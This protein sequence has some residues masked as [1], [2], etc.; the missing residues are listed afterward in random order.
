MEDSLAKTKKKG[1]MPLLVLTILLTLMTV[2]TLIP[3]TAASKVCLIGYKAHC[4][5][6]P[7]STLILIAMTG[8]VCKI[9]SKK[10][11]ETTD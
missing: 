2:S 1:Y 8:V 4:T 5:F 6:T 10:F 11:T 3:D 7:L 9:R